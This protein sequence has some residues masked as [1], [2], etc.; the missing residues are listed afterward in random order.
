MTRAFGD[1]RS[2][3]TRTLDYLERRRRWMQ[4]H[5]GLAGLLAFLILAAVVAYGFYKIEGLISER[6]TAALN[7]ESESKLHQHYSAINRAI[8]VET[9]CEK[10]IN[11]IVEYDRGF[12]K[13]LGGGNTLGYELATL[14]CSEIVEQT[15]ESGNHEPEVTKTSN[16]LVYA[17][18][19]PSK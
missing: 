17:A 6:H 10:G 13:R 9:W 16:P 8:N 18:L 12:V 2:R 4:A 15:L 19:H 3:L 1:E 5:R 11:A 14:D 7:R